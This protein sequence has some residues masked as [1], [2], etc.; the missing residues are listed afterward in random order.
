[1]KIAYVYDAVYPFTIGGVEKRIAVLSERLVARGHEVHVFGLKTWDGS[2]DFC[3]DGVHYHGVGFYPLFSTSGCRSI[4][5]AIYFGLK[6]LIPLSRERFDII[7]CQNFPYFSCFSAFFVSR[8]RKT[9]L[10]ITWHEVWVEYWDEYL[11]LLGIFGK[12]IEKLTTLLSY[13][14]VAVSDMTGND[15]QHLTTGFPVTI[16]PNGIDFQHIDAVRPLESGCDILFVGRLIREKNCEFLISAINII[17]RKLPDIR[18]IIVGEG[19]EKERLTGLIKEYELGDNVKFVGFVRNHDEVIALM[20]A[21]KIFASPSV[22]EGFGMAV[23]EAMACGL[24]VVT[25]MTGII[26]D[27]TPESFAEAVLKCLNS[28][29][30]MMEK[31]KTR[32]LSYDWGKIVSDV[33]RF[34]SGVIGNS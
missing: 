4:C 29:G 24:P 20:K 1:M 25:V 3:Q 30:S 15:L 23:L 8:I 6:I 19:P 14:Q 10:I 11:G 16:I 7:D 12:T 32:S 17:C 27:P 34:Y 2:P 26:C 31:C 21:S 13:N 22:R 28:K 5:E 18:C 9:P 33:E